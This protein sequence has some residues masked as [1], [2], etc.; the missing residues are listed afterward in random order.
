MYTNLSDRSFR[1]DRYADALE[2]LESALELARRRG[3]RPSEWSIL[4]EM[5]YP[6]Y[7]LGSWDET[8]A[9]LEDLTDEQIA[10]GAMFLSLLTSDLEI[11]IHRGAL[12]R[13][14]QLYSLFA[15]LETSADLQEHG[16]WLG[17]T[18][19]V[20][21][22]GGDQ[23]AA[24][25]AGE[26]AAAGADVLGIGHQ[27]VKQ[28]LVEATEAALALGREGRARELLAKL[29]AIPPGLRPP[30]LS[31]QAHRFRARLEGDPSGFRAA[32][33]AFGDLS[34][35]FWRA[36]ALLE[37][38]EEPGLTEA[39]EIFER[40]QATPWLERAAAPVEVIA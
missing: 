31:A 11:H 21:R 27:I 26:A 18:A 10:S 23:A 34:V 4:A 32:A 28:G 5:T 36:V 13:A 12:D 37:L 22:A 24:L 8:L 40:L 16:I 30:Y 25:E 29:D 1:R 7:M 14:Q 35:P 3:N 17:A 15:R 20:R 33:E 6:L 2:Y 9:V 19:A 39:R 38:G